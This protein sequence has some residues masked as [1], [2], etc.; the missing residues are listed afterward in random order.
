MADPFSK[1]KIAKGRSSGSGIAHHL[2]NCL[3]VSAAATQ[4]QRPNGPALAP[5]NQLKH[6]TMKRKTCFASLSPAIKAKIERPMPKRQK[7]KILRRFEE[8]LDGDAQPDFRGY[9]S[10]EIAVACSRAAVSPFAGSPPAVE[11]E[12]RSVIE[13]PASRL[14]RIVKKMEEEV[15]KVGKTEEVQYEKASPCTEG[16]PIQKRSRKMA[17]PMRFQRKLKTNGSD[18]GEAKKGHVKPSVTV[19]HHEAIADSK[20]PEDAKEKVRVKVAS[21]NEADLISNQIKYCEKSTVKP[22]SVKPDVEDERRARNVP[23]LEAGP[24]REIRRNAAKNKTGTKR[25]LK[26]DKLLARVMS[27]TRETSKLVSAI[28]AR[29]KRKYQVEDVLVCDAMMTELMKGDASIS[30]TSRKSHSGRH[31]VLVAKDVRSQKL[32]ELPE[33]TDETVTENEYVEGLEKMSKRKS[34]FQRSIRRV[35]FADEEMPARGF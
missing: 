16:R 23:K 19:R 3:Q 13:S 1:L 30:L 29:R 18:G 34:L 8:I 32:F 20:S 4:R 7:L 35:R 24:K 11:S 2:P 5:S 6:N 28:N 12:Q 15:A 26:S 10:E 33:V 31:G 27:S 25:D 21:Q 17:T 14:D 22:S 9:S